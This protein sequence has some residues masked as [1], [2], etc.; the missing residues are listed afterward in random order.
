MPAFFTGLL[1][2]GPRLESLRRI[3]K[4]SIDDEFTLLLAVGADLVGDVRVLPTGAS[5]E[6]VEP[7]A[8]V[9]R[10]WDEIVFDEVL[11]DQVIDQVAIAGVQGKASAGLLSVPVTVSGKRYILKFGNPRYPCIVRSEHYLLSAV[12][13]LRWP[14]VS[15]HVVYDKNG[16]AGLLVAAFQVA[17]EYAALQG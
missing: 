5:L 14:V 13:K 16:Q 1:P 15:S 3:I 17:A 8:K 6:S 2:E 10:R 11:S 12:R 4:T 9:V 7:L